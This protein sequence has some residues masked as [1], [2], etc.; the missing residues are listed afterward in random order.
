MDLLSFAPPE[1]GEPRPAPV[2][3]QVARDDHWGRLR[4]RLSL[5]EAIVRGEA[6]S[7]PN[8]PRVAWARAVVQVPSLAEEPALPL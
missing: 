3:R 5:A 2:H 1:Y 7:E 8:S 6:M 4:N